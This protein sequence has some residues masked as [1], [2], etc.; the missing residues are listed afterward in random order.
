MHDVEPTLVS[1]F[2]GDK[3]RQVD[4][5][6]AMGLHI[7]SLMCTLASLFYHSVS[8]TS[9][10][11]EDSTWKMYTVDSTFRQR[12]IQYNFCK[13]HSNKNHLSLCGIDFFVNIR[14]FPKIGVPQN[15]WFIMENPIKNGMIWGE[16]PLFSETSIRYMKI[17]SCSCRFQFPED[18]IFCW[19]NQD[20]KKTDMPMIWCFSHPTYYWNA[21]NIQFLFCLR[22]YTH[23]Y[24]YI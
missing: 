4:C 6:H 10:Q 22:I 16:N 2:A 1:F 15:G 7:L 11:S 13:N 18:E 12:Y 8:Y 19:K 9:S 3:E 21:A 23:M 5:A 17:R 14:V 24:I 20:L